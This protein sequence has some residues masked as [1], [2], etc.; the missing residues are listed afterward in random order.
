MHALYVWY[1]GKNISNWG[2]YKTT[3]QTDQELDEATIELDKDYG[4]TIDLD[5]DTETSDMIEEQMKQLNV[6]QKY[7]TTKDFRM[8][9]YEKDK[10]SLQDLLDN[11]PLARKAYV[12]K[13]HLDPTNLGPM[14]TRTHRDLPD[15]VFTDDPYEQKE[16]D[17][18]QGSLGKDF[19]SIKDFR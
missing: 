8:Q 15:N 11:N 3:L 1:D 4:V 9:E 10:E 5:T 2:I 16:Y 18:Y 7:M 17:V 6:G 14:A 19:K 12:M 13:Y